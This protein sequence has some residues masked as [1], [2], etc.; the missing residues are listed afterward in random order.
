L[1]FP[2]KI[3][4]SAASKPTPLLA[5]VIIMFIGSLTSFSES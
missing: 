4:S 2:D 3:S 5:P 1:C